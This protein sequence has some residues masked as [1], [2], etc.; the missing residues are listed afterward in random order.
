M[1]T[2][3]FKIFLPLLI[4]TAI[5]VEFIL[6]LPQCST[7][8]SNIHENLNLVF[9]E[10]FEKNVGEKW[11]A[12]IISHMEKKCLKLPAI[13]NNYFAAGASYSLDSSVSYDANLVL[14]IIFYSS[15][16]NF[17]YC[18][19]FNK[20]QNDNYHYR[21]KNIK[22]NSWQTL[23]LN[24]SWFKDNEYKGKILNKDDVI[25]K[26]NFF[27]GNPGSTPNIY[28]DE[29]KIY[30]RPA[31]KPSSGENYNN[32]FEDFESSKRLWKGTIST[33]PPEGTK[34]SAV[35]AIEI[36][37][38][39]FGVCASY[40]SDDNPIFI[41]DKNPTISF[42]YYIK[43]KTSIYVSFFNRTKNDNYHYTIKNITQNK[44]TTFSGSLMFFTDNSFRGIPIDPGDEIS[45]I[46]IFAGRANQSVNLW[47]DNVNIETKELS[48]SKPFD[49]EKR[50]YAKYTLINRSVI[51]KLRN[52]HNKSNREKTIL[53]VGDSISYSMAFMWPMRWN[54]PGLTINEGYKY[55]D[56]NTAAHSDMKSNWG[57]KVIGSALKSIKPEVAT[58]LF[59]TNDIL[60]NDNPGKY[61]SNMEHII[62]SCLK[63]GTIPI[64]LTIPPTTLKPIDTVKT[65]NYQ[66]RELARLKKI[67][68]LDVF[69]MF[70]DQSNWKSLLSDGV[71]PSYFE[72]NEACGYYLINESL[73]EMYKILETEV[74]GRPRKKLADIIDNIPFSYPEDS[75]VILNYNFNKSKEGWNGK[76]IKKNEVP[77][78]DGC[79][80]LNHGAELNAK[81]SA[82]FDV[83]PSTCVA[84]SVYAENCRRFRLQL[85]N[86]THKD[87]FWAAY[88]KVPQKKWTT[89]Y[90]DLNKDFQDNEH[91][92]K[93][94]FF[95][96]NITSINI[97]ADIT[98]DSSKLYIDEVIVYNATEQSYKSTLNKQFNEFKPEFD[99]LSSLSESKIIKKTIQLNN[100]FQK[101]FKNLSPE[102]LKNIFSEYKNL[103]FKSKMFINTTK[104]FSAKNP[105]FGVGYQTAMKRISPYHDL[106]KFEGKITSNITIYS[107]KNEYEIFQL[108]LVPFQAEIKNIS[109]S[110]SDFTHQDNITK[111]SNENFKTYI[112][113]F[114]TT[115]ESWPVCKYVLGKKPDPL[116]PLR[117]P[118]L[119]TNETPFLV[120]CY[121]PKDQKP[122]KYTGS[123]T[124]T[125]E[126]NENFVFNIELQVWNFTIPLHGRLH[127][128]TT[129]DFGALKQF[130][131]SNPSRDVRR[132]WYKFCLE[133]RIDPTDLY[134]LGISPHIED[135][136]YC[137][138]LGLRTIL[139][140][141]NH[142]SKNIRNKNDVKKYHSSLKQKKLL[143][144][145]MIY[146]S[147]EP[148]KK[149][150]GYIQNK[151]NW[152]KTNCP[153]LLTFAGCNPWPDLYGH[154]DVWDPILAQGPHLFDPVITKE[155]QKKGDKVM[156]YVAASPY[157]PYPN[158]QIDNDLI[159]A[160]IL[161]WM[162]VKYDLDG[163]EYYYINIWENNKY[164][165]N[166]KKWPNIPWDTYSF[167]S[168]TNNYNGDGMLIYPGP[169]MEPYSSMRLENL[170]DGIEDFETLNILKMLAEKI[171]S[172]GLQNDSTEKLMEEAQ[173]VINIPEHIVKNTGSFTRNPKDITTERIKT[174]NLIEKLKEYIND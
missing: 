173:E 151:S 139:L 54:K 69:Q 107:A 75:S 93:Q 96:D 144:K 10:N 63:Q 74:I 72:D 50:K 91:K 16:A 22:P 85:Y 166:G 71:H 116:I 77:G 62:D 17:L 158:I 148:S 84:V 159:E 170:R 167:T 23:K 20:N 46:R 143:H 136:D 112:Q 52:I 90:F 6:N 14:E 102:K 172:N 150:M 58:I 65:F 67:P 108:Y 162:T 55:I 60:K 47:V 132:N 141:G 56:K 140:G 11:G 115:K 135:I 121:T 168:K 81:V 82:Q 26:L 163:F 113:G 78:S 123:I 80:R 122:G 129:L 44:W 103:I 99:E 126:N 109:F 76:L 138:S 97:Y 152:I 43:E 66:L 61:Y 51:K 111:F 117:E 40:S 29:I 39:W 165:K 37:D 118:F 155:R 110:F 89:Y 147:D 98:D 36:E 64:L 161:L 34:G 13:D 19:F 174:G 87:N 100:R 133:H 169:D 130:Y 2:K 156:W 104:I 42:S 92:N 25:T 7:S 128:P 59:G 154:I 146:I 70:V 120:T 127:T 15:E 41:I 8:K 160:R 149:N 88:I 57:K 21:Y 33:T 137:E 45:T 101:Q 28:I 83:T 119:L 157:Y 4:C 125:S 32:F 95:H 5:Y 73:Y 3:T 18:S 24:L 145:S 171:K 79:L 105:S 12:K 27:S 35:K 114:V 68:V 94:I 53:N 31:F 86:K 1:I 142:Y 30:M 153:G 9:Y 134:H 164:A 48:Q 131:G 49:M 38:K 106:Y 124:V